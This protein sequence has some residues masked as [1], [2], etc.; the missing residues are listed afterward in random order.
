M[1]YPK[2]VIPPKEIALKK[3]VRITKK[4]TEANRGMVFEADINSSNDYYLKIDRALISKR[5]TPIN[6]VKVDYSNGAKITQA[7]FEKQSTTDYNGVYRGKYLDFEAK[8]TQSTT[9]FPLHNIAPQQV[10]HLERVI[11]HNGIA[12]FLINFALLNLTY[13]LPAQYICVFY[14]EKPRKSIP[15]SAIKE[16]GILIKEGILPRYEYLDAVDQ[17]YFPSK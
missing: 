8:S 2:G 6:V 7:Y 1:K 4:G 10:E 3:K 5:P 14:R 9:S 17:Y 13:L 16:H 11:R 15:L 12:F